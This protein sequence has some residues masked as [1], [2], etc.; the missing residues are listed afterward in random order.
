MLAGT[1]AQTIKSRCELLENKNIDMALILGSGLAGLMD[2]VD[3]AVIIPYSELDGFPHAGVEGHQPDLVIG[4]LAG[5]T[6]AVLG[7][8][9][10]YYEQGDA[11]AMR[12]PLETLKALGTR[13]LL[14]T[15]SAGTAH[16]GISAGDFMLI[17]DHLNLTGANPLI[18]ESSN[19][20]FVDMS[21]AYDVEL[22]SLM[23]KAA[24]KGKIPLQQG[25][26][27]WLAGPSFETPAEVRMA[28]ILGADAVGM[29]T[30]PEVILARFLGMK[31]VALSNITNAGAGLSDIEL[32]HEHTRKSAAGSAENFKQLIT[33]FLKLL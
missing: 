33:H 30:V 28:H 12:L 31:V 29:S 20:R 14:L 8:R 17:N 6:V 11:A 5:L 7:G 21:C 13:T 4:Q 9:A 3:N 32:S 23:K 19:N 2:H 1:L 25:V 10:H 22:Q 26:Y 15:N 18:G 24:D 16:H 27:A